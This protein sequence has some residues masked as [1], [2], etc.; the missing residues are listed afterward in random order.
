MFFRTFVFNMADR[1]Q[2]L[3]DAIANQ[4]AAGE[5]IQRPASAV[6]ELM[7][8]AIDAGAT[9]IKLFIKDAGKSLIQITDNGCGMSETD[10]RLCFERHATSKIKKAQD[11]F[12]IKTMGFRGE[13]LASIAAVAQ[14]EVKTRTKQN[15]LGTRIIIEG[16]EVKTQEPCQCPVGTSFAIKNLFYNIP[17][18]RN[19]LKSDSVETRHIVDEFQRIALAN[20]QLKFAF[21]NNDVPV[22]HLPPANLRKRIVHLFG[23]NYKERL[24]P[25]EETTDFLRVFGFIGK[26][27]FAKKYRG[28]QF[29]FVNERFIK[30]SYLNHALTTAYQELLKPKTYPFYIVFIDIDPARI[31][32]NVHP[33]KQEIKFEDEKII[34]SFIHAA[35]KKA[36]AAHN[37]TPSIDFEQATAWQHFQNQHQ[38]N[39]TSNKPSSFSSSSGGGLERKNK[40]ENLF[41]QKPFTKTVPSNWES[42][43]ETK[44]LNIPKDENKD[45]FVNM[46]VEHETIILESSGNQKEGL[47]NENQSLIGN[48]EHQPHQLHLCYIVCQIKSGF[49]LVHQQAA[50]ERILYER[51]LKVLAMAKPVTQKLLFPQEVTLPRAEGE[52]FKDLLPQVKELGYEIEMDNPTTFIIHGIPADIAHKPADQKVVIEELI[53]QFKINQPVVQ[54]DI[55]VNLAKSIART[56][57]IKTGQKLSVAEMK[58]LVDQLFAC[59]TPYTAPNGRPTFIQYR[60]EQIER[61]FDRH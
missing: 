29:F 45:D 47:L 33:T 34:Y 49:I 22:F 14:V 32:V 11:L 52:M 2:V 8:N 48:N 43:Y 61:Q 21:F 13:A 25:V 36:L 5:V 17:A 12:S 39:K 57:A 56:N 6:K 19:F 1:I 59:E 37:I 28:E 53:E 4:I 27:E 24:V 44:E 46:N 54:L 15:E 3:P 30:S 40:Q 18:R 7:E 31:D 50:H 9:D 51:F 42:V 60:L 38:I 35:V 26:P 20:S 23:K 10:A 58:S 55:R 16:S 41:P